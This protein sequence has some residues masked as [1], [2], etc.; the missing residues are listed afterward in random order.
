M[1]KLKGVDNDT[2][3]NDQ[4]ITERAETVEAYMATSYM[5]GM[6]QNLY[7]GLIYELLNAYI[8]GQEKYPKTLTTAYNMAIIWK[9]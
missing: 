3:T 7:S 5:I 4:R 9:G 1:M 2:D 8:K 6:N